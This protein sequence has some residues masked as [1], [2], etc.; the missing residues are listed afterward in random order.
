MVL[1]TSPAN[2]A[3]SVLDATG[4]SLRSSGILLRKASWSFVALRSSMPRTS[5][6]RHSHS[7]CDPLDVLLI[8]Y[9]TPTTA[10]PAVAAV[11]AATAPHPAALTWVYPSYER[12]WAR[13]FLS[14]REEGPWGRLRAGRALWCAAP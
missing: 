7:R 10:T 1:A 13:P 6:S 4:P 3:T 11:A 9:M 2:F 8:A 14:M 12:R 5:R